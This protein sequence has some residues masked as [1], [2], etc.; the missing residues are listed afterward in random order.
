MSYILVV[1]DEPDICILLK[2]IF[3]DDGSTVRTAANSTEALKFMSNEEPDLV[4]LDIWLR[5]S[6][7]DGIEILKLITKESN[8]IPVIIISGHGNIEVAVEAVKLGAYD[9]IE[10]PFNTEQILLVKNKAIELKKLKSTILDLKNKNK[11]EYAMVGSSQLIK[12]LKKELKQLSDRN[13]RI[14]LTGDLGVGKETAAG[15]MHS[16][17]N[18]HKG[19]F[20]V[21]LC[22]S[23]SD[24]DFDEIFCGREENGKKYPGIFDK[25]KNGIVYLKEITELPK[26]SQNKLLN[27]LAM[28]SYKR[29]GGDVE[30]PFESRIISGSSFSANSMLEKGMIRADLFHRLNV[31]ELKIP[32]L[33]MR[34][35]DIADLVSHFL[36]TFHKNEKLP[37]RTISDSAIIELRNIKWIGNVRQLRNLIERILI[38][39]AKSGDITKEEIIK[40]DE[41]SGSQENILDIDLDNLLSMNLK[42]ARGV[43]ERYY[44]AKQ[45]Q[46]FDGNISKTAKFI[47]MERSALHRKL[48]DLNT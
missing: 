45:V 31:I 11:K 34:K 7:L 3:E 4:I 36:D 28:N 43:F 32:A 15:Y 6:D 20:H 29:C 47:G 33:I 18:V 2:G 21:V 17:S 8:N 1:D 38:L 5:N 44:L 35:E 30:I 40:N 16:I 26:N 42:D 46:S 12:S 13:S 24:I 41:D 19:E 25:A 14:L 37:N 27:I 48:K 22:S 39:G 9:F 10:K 23:V